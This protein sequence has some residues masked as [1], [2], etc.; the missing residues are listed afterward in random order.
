MKP[1][2]LFLSAILSALIL[3]GCGTLP[4][5]T[6]TPVTST[7]KVQVTVKT[8]NGEDLD[9]EEET[10]WK[11]TIMTKLGDDHAT[12]WIYSGLSTSDYTRFAQDLEWLEEKTDIR[13]V[14]VMI[15]SPGGNAFTGLSISD[16]I[17]RYRAKGFTIN[18]H[19]SGIIAS[20][21]VPIFAAG[22]NRVADSAAIFMVHEAALWKW[23]GRETASDI[24]AQNDL[25]ELLREKYMHF[26]VNGSHQDKKAWE[27]MEAK[28]SWF[29]AEKALEIGLAT[30]V[31]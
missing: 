19:G 2:T 12:V 24:R 4:R 8:E 6:S 25:M 23:P 16:L 1:K 21:A 20:A 15:N 7:H 10:P 29:S 11:L 13:T 3:A 22:E 18:T 28:T 27:N 31:E 9:C 14:K 17:R 5:V 30:E 26:L